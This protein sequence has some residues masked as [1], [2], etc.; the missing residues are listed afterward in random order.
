MLTQL[1]QSLT[2][3]KSLKSPTRPSRQPAAGQSPK[4]R[5][6]TG[7]PLHEDRDPASRAT[8]RRQRAPAGAGASAAPERGVL[9]LGNGEGQWVLINVSPAVAHRLNSDGR[10]DRHFGL[11]DAEVRAVVLTDPQID[12]VG[13]L[14]SLRGGAPIDL[15]ATPAVFEQLT[16]TL[17]VLPVLQHYCGVHWHVVPVA[18]DRLVASFR[19][20]GLP[21]LEFTAVASPP[22]A[23]PH[24]PGADSPK[25]GDRFALAV[26]DLGTGQRLFCATGAHPPSETEIAWMHEADCL[27]LDPPMRPLVGAQGEPGHAN[28][29]QPDD[30]PT[31]LHSLPARHKVLL[32]EAAGHSR[33]AVRT[34][35]GH[36]RA[37]NGIALA[38]DGMEIDL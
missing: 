31:L 15:H 9:A 20:E 24:R 25:V 3:L 27:L 11:P 12:S 34:D 18:G 26:R 8:R 4:H 7:I 2:S 33:R 28:L 22:S 32:G 36:T 23:S 16:T 21:S 6:P 30:W 10:L 1:T 13:G 14:L 35:P 5:S 29:A 38:Y 19:V 37:N 17:P